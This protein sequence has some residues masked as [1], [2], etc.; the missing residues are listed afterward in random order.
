[1]NGP[2][3]DLEGKDVLL[4]TDI[5]L[6]VIDGEVSADLRFQTYL[7]TLRELRDKGAR[8]FV[9]AHQ[10]RAGDSDFLSLQQHAELLGEH[11]G[12]DV[13]LVEDFFGDGL[14]RAV[15]DAEDGDVHLIENIR[16]MSEDTLDRTPEEHSEAIYVQKMAPHLDVFINDAFS[17]AHR[18]H[19]STTGFMPLLDTRAGRVMHEEVEHLRRARDEVEEPVLVLGGEKTTDILQMLER[20][21]ERADHVLLGGIPGELALLTQGTDLGAKA[22]WIRERGLD[23][24]QDELGEFVRTYDDKITLPQDVRT[25]SGTAPV[26]AVPSGAMTWDIGERTAQRFGSTIRNAGSVIAKGPMGAFDEG[27]EA[28]TRAVVGAIAD[29]DGYTVLGGGHTSSVVEWFGFGVEEFSHVSI[30]GG[31]FVRF[32]SGERLGVLDALER[33]E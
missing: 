24:G 21:I 9:L 8:T 15:E 10:G 33:Y 27:H 20:M 13:G 23:E 18:V 31:A 12:Q 19:A 3:D 2:G 6:P 1:M 5:N 29:C 17:A 16:M 14:A 4:R 11:L 26:D 28:G 32:M 30:A 22:D 7:K 25:G